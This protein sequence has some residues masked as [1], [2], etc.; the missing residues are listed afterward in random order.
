MSHC[1]SPQ[2]LKRVSRIQ[3]KT[4]LHHI[5]YCINV[6]RETVRR[7]TFGYQCCGFRER[8][9]GFYPQVPEAETRHGILRELPWNPTGKKLCARSLAKE[10][11]DGTKIS[12]AQETQ[13]AIHAENKL[14][15]DTDH[16]SSLASNLAAID[17]PQGTLDTQPASQSL[18]NAAMDAER[19]VRADSSGAT[20]S[21]KTKSV[22]DAKNKTGPKQSTKATTSMGSNRKLTNRHTFSWESTSNRQVPPAE[23][24]FSHP[25]S[26]Q[27][28]NHDG[29]PSNY[30]PSAFQQPEP[31][32]HYSFPSY[33]M[34]SYG[35]GVFPSP[36]PEMR[37]WGLN[38]PQ[39]PFP[40]M[41]DG[42]PPGYGL[43]RTFRP[44]VHTELLH[45]Y[46]P[47]VTMVPQ[48]SVLQ[49]PI[50][51]VEHELVP[52]GPPPP[53]PPPGSFVA[54][55]SV[56]R[57]QHASRTRNSR[58]NPVDRKA[59]L[60][61]SSS[62]TSS[63]DSQV[64][65]NLPSNLKP[66]QNE[67]KTPAYQ[68][69]SILIPSGGG[70]RTT[71]NVFL[72]K[73]KI[74]P[75]VTSPSETSKKSLL[76]EE[77]LN[78]ESEVL[79]S[80]SST[81][82]SVTH[83]P[84]ESKDSK[85]ANEISSPSVAHVKA[86]SDEHLL[87]TKPRIQ[88]KHL[89]LNPPPK[90][91]LSTSESS[92][93]KERIELMK[94]QFFPE[95]INHDL[96]SVTSSSSTTVSPSDQS[97]RKEKLKAV[98]SS[99]PSSNSH[100]QGLSDKYPIQKHSAISPK[101]SISNSLLAENI[102]KDSRGKKIKE[103]I[104]MK[105]EKRLFPEKGEN[106]LEKKLE[107]H[108]PIQ[109]Q[110][111]PDGEI[112]KTSHGTVSSLGRKSSLNAPEKSKEKYNE[113]REGIKGNNRFTEKDQVF[114]SPENV[115]ITVTKGKN[116]R[117][118]AQFH[119]TRNSQGVDNKDI[120]N[121]AQEKPILKTLLGGAVDKVNESAGIKFS[122]E[123]E[124]LSP[125]SAKDSLIAANKN[126]LSKSAD[127]KSPTDTRTRPS[128]EDSSQKL[129]DHE[130]TFPEENDPKSGSQIINNS[131]K[132]SAR[133]KKKNKQSK[134]LSKQPNQTEYT[135]L[136]KDFVES[137]EALEE[138]NNLMKKREKNP[139]ELHE[140]KHENLLLSNS[141]INREKAESHSKSTIVDLSDTPEKALFQKLK[142]F[143]K[144]METEKILLTN[145]VMD[146]RATT[147]TAISKDKTSVIPRFLSVFMPWADGRQHKQIYPGILSPLRPWQEKGFNDL[148]KKELKK[149]LATIWGDE[150]TAQWQAVK[151]RDLN[152][153][154]QLAEHLKILQRD[155]YLPLEMMSSEL[156]GSL[157]H[158]WHSDWKDIIK[159]QYWTRQYL[160][161]SEGSRRIWT[162]TCQILQHTIV[163]N[164]KKI[165]ETLLST[166]FPDLNGLTE[167]SSAFTF[168][169]EETLSRVKVPAILNKLMG[170]E[171][172]QL[173]HKLASYISTRK[174]IPPTWHNMLVGQEAQQ[175]G[176]T[177]NRVLEIGCAL[178]LSSG[179]D[180]LFKYEED[181]VQVAARILYT[182][183]FPPHQNFVHWHD[184]YERAW[185][186]QHFG[187][188]YH[189]GLEELCNQPIDGKKLFDALSEK[190]KQMVSQ[191]PIS[192]TSTN[193]G[194]IL[195]LHDRGVEI[196]SL[197]TVHNAVYAGNQNEPM[198]WENLFGK[199]LWQLSEQHRPMLDRRNERLNSDKV[200]PEQGDLK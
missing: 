127:G 159:F 171:E 123:R 198:N 56:H 79:K 81:T 114:E 29:A 58:P 190:T 188:R 174:V 103:E 164:W 86:S 73:G 191:L 72:T 199:A 150:V 175:H 96:K 88:T 160:G 1:S 113:P 153:A 93:N 154:N 61:S 120:N 31:F 3:R 118:R 40:E 179:D 17:S 122:K 48:V 184:S 34:Q 147:T 181:V 2:F 85:A 133:I 12:L 178:R 170:Y 23:H 143:A 173:R 35:T 55:R 42:I 43:L 155:D 16:S 15:T 194:N 27:P 37:N 142:K 66:N 172:A 148:G 138:E 36:N 106:L 116:A 131:E 83:S 187:D 32:F 71:K 76:K 144:T 8:G 183:L 108:S 182:N 33:P 196:K 89:V 44:G 22:L 54:D 14:E 87:E 186:V 84:S 11:E 105:Q 9:R 107:R 115:W 6:T 25:Y 94:S 130:Y 30:H 141:L 135:K 156:Y 161:E 162:L 128:V 110:S 53:L 139:I 82:L 145:R 195:R 132:K 117:R 104:A 176:L 5:S 38:P 129:L 28:P 151:M 168:I 90:N 91:V 63:K 7:P 60:S 62:E 167:G 166:L 109:A 163:E 95:S 136:Y 77:A 41:S 140:R 102:S 67:S 126:K 137:W 57:I 13:S 65:P 189:Q 193:I 124:L 80:P 185:L 49:K 98:L 180:W 200:R 21:G 100:Q 47:V 46:T 152:L 92:E 69:S 149:K 111:M 125:N 68:S 112:H 121:L 74:S 45:T 165:K 101:V 177:T 157:C 20:S 158:A 192:R 64:N 51:L 59:S 10:L 169:Q 39:A 19:K 197:E 119:N 4:P 18:A 24:S 134:N 97:S 75:E 146:V 50:T 52:L 70:L 78:K 26:G 99:S